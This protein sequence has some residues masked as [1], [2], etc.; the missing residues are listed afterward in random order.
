MIQKYRPKVDYLVETE[1]F[2]TIDLGY[3]MEES[4]CPGWGKKHCVIMPNVHSRDKSSETD[5]LHLNA[6]VRARDSSYA[7]AGMW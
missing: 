5:G 1:T 6:T 4:K 3:T 7:A 2:D